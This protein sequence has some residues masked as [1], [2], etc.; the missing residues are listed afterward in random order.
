MNDILRLL[1][2]SYN[3][4][5]LELAIKL[6]LSKQYLSEIERGTRRITD[7][8]IAKYCIIFDMRGETLKYYKENKCDISKL[9]KDAL[10][11]NAKN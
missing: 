8:I 7:D 9:L 3:Y 10:A 4:T 2:N 6:G 1:R 5:L 11:R